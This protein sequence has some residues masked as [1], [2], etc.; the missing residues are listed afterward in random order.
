DVPERGKQLAQL[1]ARL[2]DEA[3]QEGD[4]GAKGRCLRSVGGRV[5]SSFARL[6]SRLVRYRSRKLQPRVCGDPGLTHP[7]DEINSTEAAATLKFGSWNTVLGA[8]SF[9]QKGDTTLL[10]YVIFA[11]KK[12]ATYSPLPSS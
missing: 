5:P 6:S 10:D 7:V 1:E 3:H 9:D 4:A 11:L 12:D 2:P 8:I